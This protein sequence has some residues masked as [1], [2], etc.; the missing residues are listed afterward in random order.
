MSR[1]PIR[2]FASPSPKRAAAALAQGDVGIALYQI[3]R[4]ELA[5]LGANLL[6]A[7]TRLSCSP[8]VRAWDFLSIALAVHAADRFVVR[9]HSQDSWTRMIALDV[10]LSEPEP[11]TAQ[12]NAIAHALRFLSSDIWYLHFRAG[13]ASPPASNSSPTD[14]DCACL[15]SGG[16]DSLI[17]A[18]DLQCQDR[19]PLLVS[20]ASPKEGR[21]QAYLA[22]QIGLAQHRFEGRVSERWR[23]PYEPSS[24]T[25]SVLFIGYGAVAAS[26][27]IQDGAAELI[28]PENGLISINAPL[29]RRR[30][31]SL[32]T[33]TTHPYFIT[34]LQ[35]VFDAV[36]LHVNLV[37]PYG[38]K[39]KGEMLAE[40]QDKDITRLAPASYSCGK[41]KRL[42]QHCGRCVPCLI[43][44]ASFHSAG[45]T[46]STDY[47]AD[48]LSAHMAYEDV[49]SVRFAAASLVHC[50][51][52]R[53]A[54]EAGPL[55]HDRDQ[56]SCYVDVVRRGTEELR[57]FFSTISWS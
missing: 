1:A 50:D 48:D 35:R 38:F 34:S 18:M 24:R 36:D 11:W 43:R 17:G 32:S 31:G 13:G 28:V 25:R 55:S 37:N 10:E 8:S 29:T 23:R 6:Q 40:C 20:Q 21:I 45:L 14:R 9:R 46:D 15:F 4:T 5:G 49:A 2:V 33:R 39:T 26:T 27:V 41:G 53:W 3:G 56:R 12:A 19:R 44:R 22:D 47:R 54:A 57:T 16:L 30:I 52:T 51:V 42:N 7:A